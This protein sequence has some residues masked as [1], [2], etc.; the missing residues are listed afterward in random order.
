MTG[1]VIEAPFWRQNLLKGDKQQV[2]ATTANAMLLLTHNPMLRGLAAWD[3][4]ANRAVITRAPPVIGIEPMPGPYP[5][6]WNHADYACLLAFFQQTETASFK[7]H[8]VEQAVEA[9][10]RLNRFHPIRQYLSSLVWDGEARVDEWLI[11]ALGAEDTPYTRLVSRFH[12]IASVRR[13]MRPGTKHDAMPVLQGAQGIGKSRAI[14]TLHGAEWTTDYLPAD[15]GSRDA[16]LALMGVW[17]IELAE[18]DQLVRSELETIKAFLSRQVDRYRPPY[19]RDVVDVPRQCVIIGTSNRTDYLRDETGNRRFWPIACSRADLEWLA[20]HRDQLWA[21]AAIYEAENQEHW[22]PSEM[23]AIAELEASAHVL[24]D[25]WDEH[26]EAWLN[27]QRFEGRTE[28]TI[29]MVLT[30]AL[31]IPRERQ[32]RQAV[33][34]AAA[35]LRRA[36]WQQVRTNRK[37]LWRPGA[38][39]T[40]PS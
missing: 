33:L 21:E 1:T 22:M 17:C 31:A 16:A 11:R 27:R 19:G 37:R 32:N 15:L 24:E 5:R 38:A 20:E 12:M 2:L 35:C 25:A 28:V 13:I 29:A 7:I 14:R 26:V 18:L 8:H 6:A 3:D 34:R 23:R 40:Q 36:G 4:F 9:V 10:A 39:D 30:D